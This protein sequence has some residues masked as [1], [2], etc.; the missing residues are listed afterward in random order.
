MRLETAAEGR[1]EVENAS[2]VWQECARLGR[3]RRFIRGLGPRMRS[4]RLAGESSSTQPWKQDS[5]TLEDVETA[6]PED[7]EFGET[8]R[9]IAG[10]VG[11]EKF[12]E[13]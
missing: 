3:T 8:W 12:G 13:T 5:G 4:S 10:E 2:R 11:G 9:S 6:Q 1:I 7:A